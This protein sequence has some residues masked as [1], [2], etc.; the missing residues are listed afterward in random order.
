[1]IG[2][3][4]RAFKQHFK[5]ISKNPPHGKAVPVFW[6]NAEE[7][8]KVRENLREPVIAIGL[9]LLE[10]DAERESQAANSGGSPGNGAY[11]WTFKEKDDQGNVIRTLVQPYPKPVQ[12]VWQVT[13][14]APNMGDVIA[15]LKE[16]I[17]RTG[18]TFLLT[19]AVD[20]WGRGKPAETLSTKI[21]RETG[22]VQPVMDPGRRGFLAIMRF[23]ATNAWLFQGPGSVRE[24]PT[25]WNFDP[26]GTGRGTIEFDIY[27][28]A[29]DFDTDSPEAVE[30]FRGDA[31]EDPE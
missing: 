20:I 5:E 26:D 11:L 1:M 9:V 29:Q 8:A 18:T 4:N 22:S 28:R 23:R 16:A 2:A 17:L 30:T 14:A 10:P 15:I 3:L 31:G 27:R 12:V 24:E 25:W 19:T 7:Y 21:V 13:V 6:D